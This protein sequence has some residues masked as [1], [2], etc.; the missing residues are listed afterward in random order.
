MCLM[1]S[2]LHR[3]KLQIWL[4]HSV[5]DSGAKGALLIA[6]EVLVPEPSG[7]TKLCQHCVDPILNDVPLQ[8]MKQHPRSKASW[9]G[10]ESSF[11]SFKCSCHEMIA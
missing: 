1:R 2:S 11:T 7:K 10:D 4:V 9:G 5:F 6:E 3:G 8:H